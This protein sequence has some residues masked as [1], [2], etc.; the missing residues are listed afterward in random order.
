M[1]KI[2]M[3]FAIAVLFATLSTVAAMAQNFAEWPTAQRE[4]RPYT[5]WW[6]M[7]SAVDSTGLRWNME[8][9]AAAGLGGV[10]ITPIY[11]VQG[12]E[13]NDI[14][15]LS[16]RWMKMLGYVEDL[17]DRL[18]MEVDMATGTGW[19]FGGPDVPLEHAASKMVVQNEQISVGRT[20]QKVKRHFMDQN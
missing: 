14:P 13:A 16:A 11:G 20:K 5:R 2:T 17:A 4:A 9:M 6:W 3:K 19:P 8:Q 1:M 7:G 18:D 12:N 10:E 15:F